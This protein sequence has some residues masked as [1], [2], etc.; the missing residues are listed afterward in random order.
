M[1]QNLFVTCK[2]ALHVEAGE[3]SKFVVAESNARDK[4]TRDGHLPSPAT[5]HDVEFLSLNPARPGFLSYRRDHPLATAGK[6]GSP[7][8]VPAE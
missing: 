5:E 1:R 8:G 4:D 3:V 2:T 6:N 7:V